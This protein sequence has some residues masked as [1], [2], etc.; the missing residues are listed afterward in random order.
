MSNYS[1]ELG[2]T[3]G[4]R[5]IGVQPPLAEEDLTALD[6]ARAEDDYTIAHFHE[7]TPDKGDAYS[8]AGFSTEGFLSPQGIERATEARMSRIATVLESQGHTV[9]L[10]VTPKHIGY[11]RHLF[12]GEANRLG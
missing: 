9:E 4:F 10:D 7:V 8:E 2:Q 3:D 12:G 11:G 6:I 5:Y 1:M